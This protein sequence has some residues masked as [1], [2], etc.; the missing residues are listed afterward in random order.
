[1]SRIGFGRG[2][3]PLVRHTAEWMTNES[4]FPTLKLYQAGQFEV[5]S[6]MIN[7]PYTDRSRKS[8]YQEEACNAAF[9]RNVI[10]LQTR[11][12]LSQYVF[13]CF[14][15]VFLHFSSITVNLVVV[16]MWHCAAVINCKLDRTASPLLITCLNVAMGLTFRWS[17][18]VI[19]SYNKTY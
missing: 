19:H 15:V 1:M 14:P 13:V 17:C 4:N 12:S 7:L 5:R 10:R 6:H 3:G 11:S 16:G 18:I 2:C 8:R 9:L